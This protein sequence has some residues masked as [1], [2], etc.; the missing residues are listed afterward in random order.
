MN[1]RI[2]L[3]PVALLA[4][5]GPARAQWTRVPQVPASPIYSV[6]TNGD[7]ITTTGDSAV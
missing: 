3:V 7:T 4:L 2:W 6:W 1:A 5:A